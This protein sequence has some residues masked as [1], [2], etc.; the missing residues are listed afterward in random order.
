MSGKKNLAV[1][2]II[3]LVFSFGL[4][5]CGKKSS[6]EQKPQTSS[7]GQKPKA[8]KS[9]EAVLKDINSIIS[10]LSQKN[11]TAKMPWMAQK[12]QE[13]QGGQNQGGS[14]QQGSGSSSSQGDGS[15][16]SGKG[17]SS[18]SGSGSGSSGSGSNASSGGSQAAKRPSQ[19]EMQWQKINMALMDIHKKWNELEPDA[20]EA[21]LPPSSLEGFE[22]ALSH[23]TQS[24]SQQKTEESL[25]ASVDLY[26]QFIGGISQI[27][28]MSTPPELYQI[29]Y[30][31]MGALAAA[32]RGDWT[33]ASDSITAAME[34]WGLLKA[35]S[36]KADKKLLDRCDFSIQDLKHAIDEKDLYMVM[37]KGDIAMT[38][39]KQLEK[40][41]TSNQQQ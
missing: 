33:T 11:M 14:S 31:T 21:G 30:R 29:E 7:A 15:G 16:G 13:G 4:V 5:G 23:L 10:E 26:E 6:P 22:K 35:Q 40:S 41:L 36:K 37:I 24:V 2:V 38:N 8:P 1:L 3:L 39:L 17:S 18:G 25:T 20:M 32:N 9:A 12:P 28:T 19:A 34:P 27:F